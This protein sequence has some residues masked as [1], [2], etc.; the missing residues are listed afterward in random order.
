MAHDPIVPVLRRRRVALGLTQGDVARRVGKSQS[1]I[2]DWESG[3]VE[4]TLTSLL[5]WVGALDMVLVAQEAARGSSLE[6]VSTEE[7][8]GGG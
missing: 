8:T 7:V 3:V 4:P 1:T 5:F 2:S 6:A